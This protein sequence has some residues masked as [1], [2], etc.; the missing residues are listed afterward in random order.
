MLLPSGEPGQTILDRLA[1]LP[2]R[3]ITIS[4]HPRL[5]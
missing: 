2:V 4:P 3:F 5:A 1:T